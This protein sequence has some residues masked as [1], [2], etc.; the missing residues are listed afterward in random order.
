[1]SNSPTKKGRGRP[2]GEEDA[3]VSQK[4]PIRRSRGRPRKV[5]SQERGD[6][7]QAKRERGRPK[8]S[9]NKK[10]AKRGRPRKYPF[11]MS[12]PAQVSLSAFFLHAFDRTKSSVSNAFPPL[13]RPEDFHF[14]LYQLLF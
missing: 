1:M 13:S 7:E 11:S 6:K 5:I 3:G 9:V 14:H 10:P 12:C 8:G 4:P 2:Q